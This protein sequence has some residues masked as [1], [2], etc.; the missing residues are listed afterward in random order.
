[1]PPPRTSRQQAVVAAA[2]TRLPSPPRCLTASPSLPPAVR[3]VQ[4]QL[5]WAEVGGE[6]ARLF[7]CD[8][9]AGTERLVR[10][11]RPQRLNHFPGMLEIARKKGLARNLAN[12]RCI[13]CGAMHL[14]SRLRNDQL[15]LAL[16]RLCPSVRRCC[17][18]A[19]MC[20]WTQ[21]N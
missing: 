10:L 17:L 9:S 12:M 1:V 16:S 13:C 8:T 5:G 15:P 21:K 19:S 20:G 2:A 7:W 11:A 6:D 4:R 14:A 18:P 3:V